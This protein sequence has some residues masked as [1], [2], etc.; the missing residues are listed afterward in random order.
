MTL[1]LTTQLIIRPEENNMEKSK[2][3]SYLKDP[4]QLP[5]D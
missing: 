2:E 3:G 5:K 4:L 1:K